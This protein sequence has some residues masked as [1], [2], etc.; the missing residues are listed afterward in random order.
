LA[1]SRPD[2]QPAFKNQSNP[3]SSPTQVAPTF[4]RHLI[5]NKQCRAEARRYKCGEYGSVTNLG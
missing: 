2:P 1:N 3:G 5:E 4:S